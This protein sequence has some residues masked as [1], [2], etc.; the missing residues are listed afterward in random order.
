MFWRYSL[1]AYYIAI[2]SPV[3]TFPPGEK[4]AKTPEVNEIYKTQDVNNSQVSGS[5]W[6]LQD[7][8]DP[9]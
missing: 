1:Y 5:S 9:A 2:F 6:N 7:S 8:Q 4:F 3:E